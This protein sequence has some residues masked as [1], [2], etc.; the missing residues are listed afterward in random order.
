MAAGSLCHHRKFIFLLGAALGMA[1]GFCTKGHVGLVTPVAG[2]FFYLLYK[3]DWK[4][5]FD[6]HWL[7]VIFFFASLFLRLSIVIICSS[8]FILKKFHRDKRSEWCK[9]YFMESQL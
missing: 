2:I 5:L 4:L 7:I 1:V 8:I 3:K 9:I 6:W